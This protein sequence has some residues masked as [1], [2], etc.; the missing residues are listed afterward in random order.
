[1]TRTILLIAL[2]ISFACV[3]VMA[4]DK[5]TLSETPLRLENLRT[6][7]REVKAKEAD[8]KEQVRK[9]EMA[10]APENLERAFAQTPSLNPAELREN[11]RRQL[12]SEKAKAEQQLSSLAESRI[13]LENAILL[14]ER[15]LSSLKEPAETRPAAPPSQV[16]QSEISPEK[17]DN[18][19]KVLSPKKKKKTRTL[20]KRTFVP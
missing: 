2:L 8:W 19:A 9:L 1:M 18:T 16:A 5:P 4:Q 13:S 10:L 11:R 6:Q 3:T 15:E 14:A 12:E 7:L 20:R 17:S